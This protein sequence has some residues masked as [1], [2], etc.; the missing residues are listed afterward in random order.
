MSERM[1]AT[2]TG[3]DADIWPDLKERLRALSRLCRRLGGRVH[4]TK[5]VETDREDLHAMYGD[6]FDRF[7]ALKRRYDP[8]GLLEN[9]FFDRIFGPSSSGSSAP[10]P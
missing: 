6:A 7:L 3:R 5:H 10:P 2:W 8:R 1:E 4:M 9:E